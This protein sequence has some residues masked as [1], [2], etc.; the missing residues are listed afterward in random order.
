[1]ETPKKYFTKKDLELTKVLHSILSNW[2]WILLCVVVCVC[3][4]KF[5]LIFATPQFRISAQ[6]LVEDN[7]KGGS[8]FGVN[9]QGVQ[10][11][12]NLFDTKS[13]VDNEV[14]ILKTRAL[15]R[16]VVQDLSLNIHY[17]RYERLRNVE[18]YNLLP[19]RLT[20]VAMYD[21]VKSA[22]YHVT[23]SGNG[24]LSFVAEKVPIIYSC[25][26]G[27][28]LRLPEGRFLVGKGD[29]EPVNKQD[30][31]GFTVSS[32]RQATAEFQGNLDVMVTN[33]NVTTVDLTLQSN[34]PMKGERVMTTLINEYLRA[35]EDEK[36]RIADSTLVFIE[37]RLAIV[38]AELAI[39]EGNIAAY[40]RNNHLFDLSEQGKAVLSSS[41]DYMS[42]KSQLE[43]QLN[44]ADTLIAYLQDEKNNLRVVPSTLILQ[45]PTF[46]SLIQRYN[47]LQ[48]AKDKLKL[49]S[50]E[51]N[52]FYINASEQILNMR[53]DL[54]GNLMSMRQSLDVSYSTING[55]D[56][57]YKNAIG[58]MPSQ[59]R[60]LIDYSR[61]Q[62]LK[63]SLYLF[64][65]QKR[66][67][68]AISK[69]SN[70]ASSRV[71]DQPESDVGPYSPRPVIIYFFGLFL[72]FV[73]P[74]GLIYVRQLTN[75]K[76]QTKDDI[77]EA[78]TIPILGEI[79]HNNGKETI[80]VTEESRKAITEQFRVVRTNLQYLLQENQKVILITSSMNGEGKS[81]T[82]I[83][84]AGVLGLS[85]KKVVIMEM[86]LR[87][88]KISYYLGVPNSI[89]FTDYL[90]GTVTK[91][92]EL[93]RDSGI[94]PNVKILSSGPIPPNP[95]ELLMNNK[96]TK[97]MVYLK[98]NF[99]YVIMDAPPA[100]MVTDAHL[101]AP[102]A[103]L[104]VF[105]IRQKY[106]FKWQVEQAQQAFEDK[107]FEKMYILIN[108]I[109][110]KKKYGYQY[111]YNYG[112]G[113]GYGDTEKGQWWRRLLIKYL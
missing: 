72:G 30:D 108:D 1:M 10:Q 77:S 90:I 101:L 11:L 60:R 73:F 2:Y 106:T 20:I 43:I 84:M 9:V 94:H 4:S 47:E 85:G 111:G 87:K 24:R 44:I 66:E 46:I 109:K 28:T 91:E 16:K 22:K 93:L 89:G 68:T 51:Q 97:M 5:Y 12:D 100:G 96:L 78:T 64:L 61:Q 31:Y 32:Y 75:T 57:F 99:D 6:I 17:F 35:N 55:R 113:Y 70:I 98:A 36:N 107:K 79:A 110:T 53:K 74:V 69:T 83:N 63:Q 45:D 18:L 25:A 39:I 81:F 21:S 71:I 104:T 58:E 112:Y 37:N 26:Y 95:A 27:D 86:D 48:I 65:M 92:T 102:H 8:N 76:I 54:I 3:L 103:D 23:F 49:T 59:E 88:P 42:K 67:E 15:M 62:Q 80:V 33:R 29:F 19:F 40:K 38:G 7:Q 50:T 14:Q 34:L 41:A 13:N 82:A 105:L 56:K 52:P